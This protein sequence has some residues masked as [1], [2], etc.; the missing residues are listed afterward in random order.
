MSHNTDLFDVSRHTDL[1]RLTAKMVELVGTVSELATSDGYFRAFVSI[2]RGCDLFD[3]PA[4][5]RWAM[6]EGLVSAN[7]PEVFAAIDALEDRPAYFTAVEVEKRMAIADGACPMC[8]THISF[9]KRGAYQPGMYQVLGHCGHFKYNSVHDPE[10]VL[11]QAKS[12]CGGRWPYSFGE[13]L[14]DASGNE[15]PG[16]SSSKHK[17]ELS[18]H[19]RGCRHGSAETLITRLVVAALNDFVRVAQ[20]KT[21]HGFGSSPTS[22]LDGCETAVSMRVRQWAKKI[23]EQESSEFR[24]NNA[25]LKLYSHGLKVDYSTPGK[26]TFSV[27]VGGDQARDYAAFV[28]FANARLAELGIL[29]VNTNNSNLAG[30]EG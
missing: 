4:M 22:A 20:D 26:V 11:R 1:S 21:Y 18:T 15:L 7:D 6:E 23:V 13:P 8:G 10:V 19:C 16:W 5:L 28:E 30:A 24:L 12:W 2:Q 27:R 3:V 9:H 14:A 25:G 17:R 29:E